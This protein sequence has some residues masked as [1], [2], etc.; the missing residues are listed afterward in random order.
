MAQIR[1]LMTAKIET[2][3]PDAT[4]RE[5]A[6]A[7]QRADTGSIP[8]LEAN[9]VVGMITDRDIAIRCIAEGRGQDCAVRDLMSKEPVFA[10]DNDDAEAV[11]QRMAEAQ[12]RRLPVIDQDQQLI[13]MIS[14]GDLSR[15]GRQ[16]A[17]SEALQGVS[18]ET[19]QLQPA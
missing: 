19:S 6:T 13:G 16:Q 9:Q 15:E 1:D 8:V 7:M 17:A 14:L 3:S 10:Y 4:V 2:V 11:A 12:V 18:A 5:A